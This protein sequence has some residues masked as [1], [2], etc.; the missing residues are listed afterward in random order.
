MNARS[1]RHP[2]PFVAAVAGAIDRHALLAPAA[3]AVVAVSGGADSVAL[4]VALALL[5]AEAHRG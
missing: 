2:D 1:P 4:L 3:G 5:A